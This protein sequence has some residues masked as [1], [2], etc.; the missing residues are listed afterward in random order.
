MQAGAER[1]GV[2]FG[3]EVSVGLANGGRGQEAYEGVGGGDAHAGTIA[4]FPGVPAD[5]ARYRCGGRRATWLRPEPLRHTAGAMPFPG[6][7]RLLLHVGVWSRIVAISRLN[8]STA[9][10]TDGNFPSRVVVLRV[11]PSSVGDT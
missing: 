11:A 2:C 7:T 10:A 6:N 3:T 8:V 1:L 4:A 5:R 9:R